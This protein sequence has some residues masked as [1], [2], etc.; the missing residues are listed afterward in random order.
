MEA[1]SNIL[2]WKIP[3]AREAGGLP[4]A[5]S[6]KVRHDEVTEHKKA[7]TSTHSPEFFQKEFP[8]NSCGC[9]SN[10]CLLHF[11]VVCL[12]F[13]VISVLA[14]RIPGTGEPGGLPSMG[15]HRVGH[16]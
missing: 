15:S 14:W 16:D 10:D 9:A 4:S 6:L 2:A 5:G 8:W 1:Y 11:N 12:I 7:N 3:W 13:K